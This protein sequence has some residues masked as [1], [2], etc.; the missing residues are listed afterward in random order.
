MATRPAV[1]IGATGQLGIDLCRRFDEAGYAVSP[2]GHADLELADPKGMREVLAR[3]RPA[4]VINAA[5]MHNVEQCEAEP[6]R[7]FAVNAVGS[8]SLAMACREL[9]AALMQVST[10]YVFDGVKG[11]PYVE[12]DCP[13]PLNVYASSKLAGEHAVLAE[14]ERSFVVRVSGLYGHA[15]CRAKGGLNFVQRMLVQ[16]GE[17][18]EIRVVDDE[19]LTPTHT[20]EVAKQLVA[21]AKSNAYGIYHAT[22]QGACSWFEFAAHILAAADY[23]GVLNRADPGEFAVKVRRPKYSVLDNAALR[24][25]GIDLMPDWRDGLDAYLRAVLE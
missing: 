1:I 23:R 10:D 8:R 13:R 6:E 11:S 3:L 20:D 22:A 25:Q 4:L 12:T 5:A 14:W 2:L 15:P 7:A 19:I 17:R 16:A 21:L 18:A 9:G 24:A